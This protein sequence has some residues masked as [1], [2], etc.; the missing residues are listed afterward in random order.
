[1]A[2]IE[3]KDTKQ[4]EKPIAPDKNLAKLGDYAFSYRAGS[5]D[6]ISRSTKY[7]FASIDRAG[8]PALLQKTG[9]VEESISFNAEF[10]MQK[11]TAFDSFRKVAAKREPMS[12]TLGTG[13]YLGEFVITDINEIR[14]VL[15]AD[16]AH[17]KLIVELKLQ[18][19]YK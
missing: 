15:F 4:N 2:T 19:F 11:L 7:N 12:L 3:P 10:V 18:R 9:G 14:S 5:F 6:E 8:V 16:G 1:M 13:E 17:R